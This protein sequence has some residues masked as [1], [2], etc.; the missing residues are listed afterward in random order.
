MTNCQ[1]EKRGK[2]LL[3]DCLNDIM[4]V[5]GLDS[6]YTVKYTPPPSGVWELLQAEGY[7]WPYIPPLVLIQIQYTVKFSLQENMRYAV[8]FSLEQKQVSIATYTSLYS[9][10]YRI[11]YSTPYYNFTNLFIW[12]DQYIGEVSTLW[13]YTFGI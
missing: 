7:I 12:L 10:M 4:S 3:N 11:I 8:Y 6:G 2:H 13:I 9:I 1:W 5:L